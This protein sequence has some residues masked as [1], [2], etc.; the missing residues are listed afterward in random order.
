MICIT[1]GGTIFSQLLSPVCNLE[2]ASGGENL[3]VFRVK[4]GNFDDE[5]VIHDELEKCLQV[6]SDLNPARGK[7]FATPFVDHRINVESERTLEHPS[8]ALPESRLLDLSNISRRR[9]PSSWALP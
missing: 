3:E 7:D 2:S 6:G 5:I 1:S 4:I 9:F 8:R